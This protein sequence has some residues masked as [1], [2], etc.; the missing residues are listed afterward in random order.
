M[1]PYQMQIFTLLTYLEAVY[2]NSTQAKTL[3]H[4]KKMLSD[5]C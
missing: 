2:A 1:F 3:R 5:L 4:E